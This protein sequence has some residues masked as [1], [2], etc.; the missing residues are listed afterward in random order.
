MEGLYIRNHHT[1]AEES[2][3]NG[4]SLL[5]K[6]GNLEVMNQH[7]CQGAVVWLTPGEDPDAFECFFVHSGR[8]EIHDGD[9]IVPLQRGDSFF[10]ENLKS[11]VQI[12]CVQ[13]ADVLYI[14]NTPNFDNETYWQQRLRQLIDRIDSKDH[15]T[16][17][18]SMSVARYSLKLREALIEHCSRLS[19]EEFTIAALFHDV[20]KCNVPDAILQKPGALTKEEYE[21]IKHH[22]AD[23][24]RILEP[25]YGKVIASIA[26]M[27]HER[28]DGTGYPNGLKGEEIPF[29]ARIIIV[30]DAFDAMTTNRVYSRARTL[31]TAAAELRGLKEQYDPIVTDTLYRLVKEGAFEELSKQAQPGM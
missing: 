27:H 17:G 5:A 25:M 9:Q 4:L 13:E 12:R 22:P 21:V 18:H 24:E 1:E 23:S 6:H 28:L 15:Y 3:E 31:E 7:I 10:T 29:E 20:G 11:D 2:N 16:K 14:C 30:A 8:L 26:S 19:M